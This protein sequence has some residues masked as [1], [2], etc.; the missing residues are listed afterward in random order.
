MRVNTKET[1]HLK[2]AEKDFLEATKLADQNGS[3][4]LLENN[5][6]I[7]LTDNEK[8]DVISKR[9]LKRHHKVFRKLAE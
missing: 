2:E 8:I 4:I 6:Y 1:L 3:V 9:I 7:E 5:P